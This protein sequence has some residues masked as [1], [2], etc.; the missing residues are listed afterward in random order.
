MR[1]RHWLVVVTVGA[2]VGV[3]FAGVSTYDFVQHLDRQI[4]SIHCSFIPGGNASL[5]ASGCQTAM[6]SPYSSVLRES[7]WGGVPIS[8]AAMSVFAF[9]AFFALDLMLS[10][11]Q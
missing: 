9:I 10:R 8:L 7:V 6:M 1:S 3:L 11:R 4:H 2:V 5:G